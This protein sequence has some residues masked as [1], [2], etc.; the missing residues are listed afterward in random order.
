ML[1]LNSMLDPLLALFHLMPSGFPSSISR[2]E[3]LKHVSREALQWLVEHNILS[4]H[5]AAFYGL[6]DE[7]LRVRFLLDQADGSHTEEQL[8]RQILRLGDLKLDEF[9]IEDY[10]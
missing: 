2:N 6:V 8:E 1:E 3:A 5:V 9:E 10:E 4:T 7:F